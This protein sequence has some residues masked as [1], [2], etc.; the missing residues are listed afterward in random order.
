ML[1][2][3]LEKE[4]IKQQKTSSWIWLAIRNYQRV[5]A[6]FFATYT[7]L[8]TLR[9]GVLKVGSKVLWF[10]C[11]FCFEFR[12]QTLSSKLITCNKQW[13]WLN[14]V[15]L[16]SLFKIVGFSLELYMPKQMCFFYLFMALLVIIYNIL[17][18][19]LAE[20]SQ[21]I[22]FSSGIRILNT[23]KV[24]FVK[25]GFSIFANL[26]YRCE[27]MVWC[28]SAKLQNTG[29]LIHSSKDFDRH[30]TGGSKWPSIL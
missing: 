28:I 25:A 3:K 17:R 30:K 19:N 12:Y 26:S 15:L 9:N 2:I 18:W 22:A 14:N 4:N 6:G 5:Y 24:G 27:K 8:R 10:E 11:R 20:F 13:S 16:S 1:K 7:S 21:H 29:Q 23:K